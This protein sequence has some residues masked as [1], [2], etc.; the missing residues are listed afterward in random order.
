VQLPYGTRP[1]E[2]ALT[3][4]HVLVPVAPPPPPPL[5]VILTEAIRRPYGPRLRDLG[6]SRVTIIVSDATRDE[7]RAEMLRAVLDELGPRTLTLAV[8]TGTHGPSRPPLPPD[9]LSR[10]S[11]V[12][13]HDGHRDDQLVALGVTPR[14]TPV[15][16]H[17]CVVE[18][19]VVVAT[20]CIRPHYFAG[21]GAGIKAVVPGLGAARDIRINHRLKAAPGARA[22]VTTGNPCREDMEDAVALVPAALFLL[23]VVAGPDGRIHHAVAGDRAAFAA[24][25]ELARPLFT[26]PAVT[27]ATV[28]ASDA[29]PVTATLYQASKIAAAVAALVEPGGTLVLVAECADGIGPVE[30]VNQAIFELGIRPR[31]APGV[32]VVLVSSLPPGVARQS[33]AVPAARVEDVVDGPFVVAPRASQLIFR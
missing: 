23:N 10:F 33:Y 13:D 20:G 31:L 3:P 24:G 7:P 30:V 28:V 22:G 5:G 32:R 18:A 17:R 19:D 29:L 2:L 8:A 12:I 4:S 14:G 15:R 9:L 1:Y 27:T 26:V 6:G 25:V 11:T 21:F 16:V